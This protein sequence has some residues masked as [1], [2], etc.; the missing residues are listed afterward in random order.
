MIVSIIAHGGE[1]FSFRHGVRAICLGGEHAA[2]QQELQ[3]KISQRRTAL[4]INR[5]GATAETLLAKRKQSSPFG[6]FVPGSKFRR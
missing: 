5:T 4:R 3:Q 2:K 1:A 6:E